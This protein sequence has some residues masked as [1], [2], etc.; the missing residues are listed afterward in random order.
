MEF[1]K[2]QSPTLYILNKNSLV[3]NELVRV[4]IKTPLIFG[5][6]KEAKTNFSLKE[7]KN[8]HYKSIWKDSKLVPSCKNFFITLSGGILVFS[9]HIIYYFWKGHKKVLVLKPFTNEEMEK[10]LGVYQKY[11]RMNYSFIS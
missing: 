8:P 6:K 2:E 1:S 5:D 9:A 4:E 11:M 10:Y 7:K 3:E